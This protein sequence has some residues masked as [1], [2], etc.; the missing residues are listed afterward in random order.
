MQ[1]KQKGDVANPAPENKEEN[2]LF[3]IKEIPTEE[4]DPDLADEELDEVSGGIIKHVSPRMACGAGTC[5]EDMK[6]GNGGRIIKL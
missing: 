1:N 2:D 4:Q 3:E 5:A 6:K